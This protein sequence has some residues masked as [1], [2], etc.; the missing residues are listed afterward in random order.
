MIAIAIVAT[1]YN[2][3]Y[4]NKAFG[5]VLTFSTF[6]FPIAESDADFVIAHCNSCKR[7]T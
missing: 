1:V 7:N 4:T 2:S 6:D 5:C 3:M